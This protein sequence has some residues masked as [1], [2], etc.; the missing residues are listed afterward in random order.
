M[1]A[2]GVAIALLVMLGSAGTTFNH[3]ADGDD[4]GW[5]LL[6]GASVLAG[7][8]IAAGLLLSRRYPWPGIGLVA[9]GCTSIAAIWYWM[10]PLTILVGIALVALAFFRARSTGWP[11]PAGPHLPTGTGAA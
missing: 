3:F 9:A 6:G 8:A 4:V 2:V 10:F 7:L 11:H 5:V 1:V